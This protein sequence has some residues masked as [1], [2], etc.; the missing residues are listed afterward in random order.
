[1]QGET[2]EGAQSFEESKNSPK[3]RELLGNL[4]KKVGLAFLATF[5]C[6]AVLEGVFRMAG[7]KALHEVYSRPEAFWRHDANLGWSMEPGSQGEF[8]GPR[9]FPVE[10]HAPIRINSLGLRGAE[11]IAL[12]PQGFRVLV[13]GD[14][15]VAGFEVDEEQTFEAILERRLTAQMG[16]S[17]QVVNAGVRGYGTDQSYIFYRDRGL[18][19]ASD[20]VLFNTA[21]NDPEDNTTLH[22]A[23][24][25]FGKP[26]FSLGRNGSL[27]LVGSP[28]PDY[29]FCS[30]VRLDENFTP[31]RIDQRRD[32]SMCWLQTA[33]TD[34]SALF[35]FITLRI[36][37]NVD[38][39]YKLFSLGTPV[40]QN[41]IMNPPGSDSPV[42]PAGKLTTRLIRELA[43]TAR[44]REAHFL[45]LSDHDDLV[46]LAT[47]QLAQDGIEIFDRDMIRLDESYESLHFRND[48][49]LNARGHARLAEF[50]EPVIL[51]HLRV[52]SDERTQRHA[53]TVG[54][55]PLD[56][57][58]PAATPL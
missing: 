25:P 47:D 49:H 16:V 52:V 23:R 45:L 11:L 56:D 19:V 28:V 18:N 7:Y 51:R 36:R 33:M 35:T 10:F 20:L 2:E 50:L 42:S 57:H 39:V 3:I 8:V 44:R 12:P 53:N 29:S 37:Q 9:P 46:M 22:R 48:S 15:V 5:L 24:R 32:R 54:T 1:M 31:I 58:L 4:S 27:Q 30:G 43:A 17:V 21:N 6:V 13:L 55:P 34:H 14:S 38:L 26:A 40:K 41:A